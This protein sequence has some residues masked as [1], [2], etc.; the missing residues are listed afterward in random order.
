M[1]R[2]GAFWVR[3]GYGWRAKCGAECMPCEVVAHASLG[4]HDT[5]MVPRKTT[6]TIATS[7]KPGAEEASMAEIVRVAM[8]GG[9]GPLKWPQRCPRCGTSRELIYLDGR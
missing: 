5:V 4:N 9:I 8:T 2:S 6:T 7:A 1:R 3:T